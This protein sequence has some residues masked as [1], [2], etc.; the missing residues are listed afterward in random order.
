[1]SRSGYIDDFDDQW[2][3]ICWR[4]AVKSAIRGKRG[5]SFL[6]EL[7]D[8]LDAMP[9]KKLISDD[10]VRDGEVCA[11]GAVADAIQTS[12]LLSLSLFFLLPLPRSLRRFPLKPIQQRLGL[13]QVLGVEAFSEPVVHISKQGAGGVLFHCPASHSACR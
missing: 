10:L 13:L 5:Q 8:A 3:L 7:R 12:S 4:G 2:S 1:M 9:I 11:I 6:R